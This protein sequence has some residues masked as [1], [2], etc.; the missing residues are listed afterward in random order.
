MIRPK[1]TADTI[2]LI[3]HVSRPS[4]DYRREVESKY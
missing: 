4:L 2:N 1:V 3:L